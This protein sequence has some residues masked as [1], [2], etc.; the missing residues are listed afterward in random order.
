MNTMK[1]SI[2][3]YSTR[4]LAFTYRRMKDLCLRNTRWKLFVSQ[5]MMSLR[6][7]TRRRFHQ[8]KF[9]SEELLP[10]INPTIIKRRIDIMNINKSLTKRRSQSIQMMTLVNIEQRSKARRKQTQTKAIISLT[11]RTSL[12]I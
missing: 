8:T 10:S 7:G 6:T 3:D 1:K 11:R 2:E 9:S 12:T 5:T 4:L